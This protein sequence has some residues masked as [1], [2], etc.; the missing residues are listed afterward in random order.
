MSDLALDPVTGD[1]LLDAGRTRLAIGAEAVRQGWASRL[2]FF[3]G[4]AYLAPELGIDYPAEILVKRPAMTVVRAI[5]M[6]ATRATPGVADVT[7]LQLALDARSRTLSVV[8][9]VVLASGEQTALELTE[10]VGGEV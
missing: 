5:F 10:T 4:E 1:L 3:R 6:A 9:E 7:T 8:A 2:T